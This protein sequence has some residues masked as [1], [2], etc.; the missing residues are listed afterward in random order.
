MLTKVKEKILARPKL[1]ASYIIL[2]F[3]IIG[4][5]WSIVC[6]P[7]HKVSDTYSG[8]PESTPEVTDGVK[9]SQKF[10]PDRNYSFFG[11]FYPNYQRFIEKGK[12]FIEIS[13]G[14]QVSQRFEY[15]VSDLKNEAYLYVQY[16]ITAG[17]QYDLK[18]WS[19]DVD[20]GTGFIFTTVATENKTPL[21]INNKPQESSLLMTF[22]YEQKNYF[23]VWY[24]ALG[25]TLVAI[26]ITLTTNKETHEK[27]K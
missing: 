22:V 8:Q 9:L 23:T 25:I 11:I 17:T 13:S 3:L 4:L 14:S 21:Y 18:L 19:E 24:F 27:A 1:R 10:T 5:L 20:K 26:Y 2:G 7:S 16:P 6:P 12:L 15:N